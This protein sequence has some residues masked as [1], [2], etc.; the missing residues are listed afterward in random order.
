[1]Q[2]AHRI[3]FLIA[4][5]VTLTVC[6]CK[7]RGPKDCIVPPEDQKLIAALGDI[8]RKDRDDE[9]T[10]EADKA[11]GRL[12]GAD[13]AKDSNIPKLT[14][15]FL[16]KVIERLASNSKARAR[17]VCSAIELPTATDD[18]YEARVLTLLDREQQLLEA[19]ATVHK[20]GQ[21]LNNVRADYRPKA[22]CSAL[23]AEA[24]RPGGASAE[25]LVATCDE[26]LDRQK[27]EV[28][29]K[30]NGVLD[31]GGENMSVRA[32]LRGAEKL[33]RRGESALGQA[34]DLTIGDI[35]ARCEK[36]RP[37]CA[38]A[39]SLA[40]FFNQT[41]DGRLRFDYERAIVYGMI[42]AA[43][44]SEQ[45]F[46]SLLISTSWSASLVDLLARPIFQALVATVETYILEKIEEALDRHQSRFITK[47]GLLRAACR[48]Y[49]EFDLTAPPSA[50]ERTTRSIILAF[51]ELEG[52]AQACTPESALLNQIPDAR[53]KVRR[54][55][56]RA[57]TRGVAKNLR[58]E[59][60]AD[61]VA[62]DDGWFLQAVSAQAVEFEPELLL[63]RTAEGALTEAALDRI[64]AISDCIVKKSPYCAR[65]G[66]LD[67]YSGCIASFCGTDYYTYFV[68][69]VTSDPLAAPEDCCADCCDKCCDEDRAIAVTV[70]E[71]TVRAEIEQ[72][73]QR[74]LAERL[75]VIRT[76]AGA[77]PAILTVSDDSALDT[78]CG[79]SMERR[80]KITRSDGSELPLKAVCDFGNPMP[81]LWQATTHIE[82]CHAGTPDK[83]Y[84]AT[85]AKRGEASLEQK[86]D[87]ASSASKLL[88]GA[89]IEHK[90]VFTGFSSVLNAYTCHPDNPKYTKKAPPLDWK[91][92]DIVALNRQIAPK[93]ELKLPRWEGTT[94]SSECP[95]REINREL[96]YLRARSFCK[97]VFPPSSP[98]SN[99]GPCFDGRFVIDQSEMVE[100]SAER[101][102]AELGVPPETGSGICAEEKIDRCING[103][104]RLHDQAKA[105]AADD[106]KVTVSFTP[107]AELKDIEERMRLLMRLTGF[108]L[109]LGKCED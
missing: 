13:K 79:P 90:V 19:E 58:K 66:T 89:G 81:L 94:P 82:S 103:N 53:G 56:R 22:P 42:V 99:D 91:A 34:R 87:L 69:P 84:Q 32:A 74:I 28:L 27:E 59:F 73:E 78:I 14:R 11:R 96:R 15:S 21:D 6:A 77:R 102:C 104:R 62:K 71:G 65:G 41:D 67:D 75:R 20:L 97:Q 109:I 76:L 80:P 64:D 18:F 24:A 93:P 1:M 60:K 95:G 10:T 55:L 101:L 12:E 5:V 37:G 25:A 88:D 47:G 54:N 33:L 63:S 45:Q 48:A 57:A 7:P 43:R 40:R 3:V 23:W 72:A 100:W 31:H 52:D 8:L 105:L 35:A 51:H 107:E 92:E 44:R 38:A 98:M 17:A 108:G 26:A 70:L 49:G 4:P 36:E 30:L 83:N 16:R 29:R 106:R 68:D 61:D 2:I 86:R 50:A 85:Q 46:D 39:F 9:A